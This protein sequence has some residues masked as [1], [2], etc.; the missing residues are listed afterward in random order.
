MAR[1]EGRLDTVVGPESHVKGDFRVAG[2]LRLDG[3]VEGR[4]DVSGTF[5][6][7]PGAVLKGE[8]RCR[9]AVVSGRVEGN[10]HASETVELQSGAQVLGNIVCK[11]LV[12]QRDCLFQ[13][14]CAM[15]RADDPARGRD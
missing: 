3:N 13:G 14:N 8:A 5:M 6:T 7:G 11:S 4:I 10:I 9:D 12:I 2:S 1:G 15:T